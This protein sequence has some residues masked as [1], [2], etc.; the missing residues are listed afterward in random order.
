[1]H[2]SS[3]RGRP[4]PTQQKTT[5]AFGRRP[6]TFDVFCT[7]RVSP[8]GIDKKWATLSSFLV[9]P[10]KLVRIVRATARLVSDLATE[11]FMNIYVAAIIYY[12]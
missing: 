5:R 6:Q 12:F 10:K 8:C 1:M 11:R 4:G 3:L 7:A 9:Q 2:A